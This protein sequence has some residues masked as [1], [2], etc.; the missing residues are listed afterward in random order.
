MR[1]KIGMPIA[2][3]KWARHLILCFIQ[4][5][6]KK[7]IVLQ[8]KVLNWLILSIVYVV[9]MIHVPSYTNLEGINLESP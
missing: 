6:Y 9:I 7:Q 4:Y 3:K 8:M 2:Y 1:N 5:P